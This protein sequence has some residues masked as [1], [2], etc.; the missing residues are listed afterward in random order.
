MSARYPVLLD[1]ARLR[2]LVV[3]GGA[4]G[5]RK[6]A[7]L[8]EAGGRPDVVSPEATAELADLVAREG[9][10]WHRRPWSAE[11]DAAGYHLVFAATDSVDVNAAVADAARSAGAMVS[12]AD[13]G[14]AGEVQV[15]STLREGDVVV[16]LSTGGASPLLARRIRERLAETVVTPG[17]GRAVR[18]LSQVRAEIQARWA[19]DDAR[20]RAFWFDLIT[21]GFLD[22]AVRGRDDEVERAISRCLSQS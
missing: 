20:R 1:V 19:G 10:V 9:L 3:G 18:R 21:P 4:V 8:V 22:H 5:A 14:D 16:A 17:L 15:P 7:G 11:T 13:Q 6:V 2:V 12:R